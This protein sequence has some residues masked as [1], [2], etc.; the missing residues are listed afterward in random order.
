MY[1]VF[2]SLCHTIVSTILH[3]HKS[4][5]IDTDPLRDQNNIDNNSISIDGAK[6]I[7]TNLTNLICL[8]ISSN[9]IDNEGA[10]AISNLRSLRTLYI[11]WNNI[12][13]DGARAISNFANLIELHTLGNNIIDEG[14]NYISNI[15]SLEV[16]NISYNKVKDK[17]AKTI[18]NLINLKILLI[19]S[20]GISSKKGIKRYLKETNP[21]LMVYV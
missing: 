10:R 3:D 17:G 11:S 2:L 16:L 4:R 13:N 7:G 15:A 1:V 14:I 9:N 21:H 18:S 5:D 20:T 19:Y 6:I 12:S 8:N